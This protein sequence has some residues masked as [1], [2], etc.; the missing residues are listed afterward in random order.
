MGRRWLSPESASDLG[1]LDADAIARVRAE[2]WPEAAN[3]DELHDALGLA[4]LPQRGGSARGSRLERLAG[5]AGTPEARGTARCAGR[6]ALDLGR[7]PAAVSGAVADG[8]ARA[9]DRRAGRPC[10]PGLVAR[11][12]AG[13]GLARAARGSGT[14]HARHACCGARFRSERHRHGL[15]GAR[16]R[17]LR[18]ARALHAGNQR[19]GMVRATAARPHSP[20]HRQAVAGGD[21]A[22]RGARFPALPAD[23]AAR[24]AGCTDGRSGRRRH[25]GRAARR[26][27]GAGRRLGNRDPARAPRRL[28]AALAR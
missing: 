6:D 26:V 14:G 28:R 8:Q 3:A 18:H 20:L 13:R 19:R 9:R 1:R 17:R 16:G 23:L 2:A 5:G 10:R 7:A 15:G 24:R 21:R 27:R 12:R 11:R 22:G 4:R 25:R